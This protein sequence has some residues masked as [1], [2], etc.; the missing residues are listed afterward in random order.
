MDRGMNNVADQELGLLLVR[1]GH[2]L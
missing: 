1:R 2:P